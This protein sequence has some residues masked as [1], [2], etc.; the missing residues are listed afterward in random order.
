VRVI[1]EEADVKI[2]LSTL[3]IVVA[4]IV[5]SIPVG[6]LL[7]RVTTGKDVR[8]VGSGRTGGANVLRVAG[9]GVALL[10][11][12]IDGAKGLLAVWLAR[13]VVQS[14]FVEAMAGLLAVVGHNYSIFIGFKGGAGTICTIGGAIGLWPWNGAVLAGAGAT[15]VVVTRHTSM[16]SIT[17]ALLL[18]IILALRI[19]LA[20]APRAHLIHG[21]GA[22][23]LTLWALRPN[24]R[25]LLEGQERQL[26]LHRGT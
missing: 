13:A 16:G 24:I 23:A 4:Y 9:S 15:A 20:D 10:T 19:W 8:D 5:G 2:F 7:A 25:R 1:V 3:V 26:T 17:I 12:L 6:L 11:V 18:P 21:L 14:P 22:S